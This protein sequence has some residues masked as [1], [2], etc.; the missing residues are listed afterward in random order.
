V[1]SSN[2][3]L[4]KE[5]TSKPVTPQKSN[6]PIWRSVSPVSRIKEDNRRKTEKK[7]AASVREP[8]GYR[9]L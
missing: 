5:A 1:K 2:Q 9:Y 3:S 7:K 6:T 4:P 8:P